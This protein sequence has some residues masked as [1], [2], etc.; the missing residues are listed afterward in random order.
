[1]WILDSVLDDVM[2][3]LSYAVSHKRGFFFE[4]LKAGDTVRV[5]E[6]T[7]MQ[8]FPRELIFFS[9]SV[10]KIG[11]I[12]PF[13]TLRLLLTT[14]L[15]PSCTEQF[16]TYHFR[17]GFSLLSCPVLCIVFLL[18]ILTISL[19]LS[20]NESLSCT[21]FEVSKSLQLK[22]LNYENGIAAQLFIMQQHCLV[23]TIV[24]SSFSPFMLSTQRYSIMPFNLFIKIFCVKIVII[25]PWF[26]C[27]GVFFFM[28]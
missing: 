17:E 27:C 5:K 22:Q 25:C 15:S 19:A 10:L 12:P 3:F 21:S 4:T 7:V 14:F 18:W 20:A 1:M 8:L 28:L 2:I 11:W 6:G 23:F 26:S 13:P 16:L 24:I 9:V